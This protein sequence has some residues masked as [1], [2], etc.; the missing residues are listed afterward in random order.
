MKGRI[1]GRL[2]DPNQAPG[3]H[4][5]G[6]RKR[7]P[8]SA[9]VTT[10][11]MLF[12]LWVVLSGKLDFFHLTL[13]LISCLIVTLI[14]KD[15]I[16]PHSHVSGFLGSSLRFPRY[17]PWLLYKIFVANVRVLYLV[18]HPKMMDLIDPR[19]FRFQSRLKKD[20]SLVTFANSITLT[21]G[22][23][24][25]YVSVNGAF[26][27]HGLDRKSREGLPGEMEKRIAGVFERE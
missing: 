1:Q 27:V 14:S 5:A 11:L 23:I 16:F 13:G 19:I 10:F 9:F 24:T 6:S 12:C 17:I 18:F 15:L 2:F 8:V 22:T 25:V 21:P 4:S 3:F 20:L 26:T 7:R